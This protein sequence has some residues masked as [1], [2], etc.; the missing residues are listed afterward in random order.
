MLTTSRNGNALNVSPLP[1]FLEEL[2]LLGFDVNCNWKYPVSDEPLL[3]ALDR[4]YY[5]KGELVAE[6]K[7]GNIFDDPMIEITDA[8]KDLKLS[9]VNIQKV[10]EK[11]QKLLFL[12]EQEAIEFI[13]HTYRL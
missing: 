13:D 5:Y 9:P 1:V 11:N 3:W 8:G 12:V 6:V 10:G 2:N 7:G 4:R